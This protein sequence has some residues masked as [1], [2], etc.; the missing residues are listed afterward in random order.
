MYMILY[1]HIKPFWF[2]RM[3]DRPINMLQ[4]SASAV[5][6]LYIE[7]RKIYI[8]SGCFGSFAECP[9]T[10]CCA[11]KRGNRDIAAPATTIFNQ[12]QCNTAQQEC[13]ETD[14]HPFWRIGG[15]T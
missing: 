10:Y 3:V 15:K 11:H 12:R 9:D 4:E 13:C 5:F 2:R 7:R 1:V 14:R 8:A 6:L